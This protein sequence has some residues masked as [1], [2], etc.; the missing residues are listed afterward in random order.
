MVEVMIEGKKVQDISRKACVDELVIIIDI[1]LPK[2][3]SLVHECHS[4]LP[5]HS[6]QNHRSHV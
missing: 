6:D 4:T 1:P 5:S 3:P 2:P